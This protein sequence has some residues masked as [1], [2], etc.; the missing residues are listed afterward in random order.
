M[1]LEIIDVEQGTEAW[2]QA[3]CGLV[4]ASNFSSV[5]AKG[6]G[7]MRRS[8]MLKVAGERVTGKPAET[9]KNP[10]MER[11]NLL[12]PVARELYEARTG[13]TVAKAGLFRD[14]NLG[15][16]PDGLVAEG[17]IFRATQP[18]I[19]EAGTTYTIPN[20]QIVLD[21]AGSEGLVEIKCR[22]AHIQAETLLCGEVPSENMAQIQG[23]LM[24]SGKAWLDYVSFCPGMPLFIK[25]VLPD[26][27]YFKTLRAELR[28]FEVEL[29]AMVEQ[30]RRMF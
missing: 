5:L 6:H 13:N 25:R 18:I 23:G 3:R 27:D 2:L 14:G 11:G 4:T 26:A 7:K 1:A 24:V 22:L 10:D 30:I 29:T 21:S 20:E 12:E 19:A 17:V 16:S 28:T 15:Y 8:Y 9:Y